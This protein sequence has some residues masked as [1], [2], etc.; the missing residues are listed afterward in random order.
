MCFIQLMYFIHT[1]YYIH[2]THCLIHAAH[3][4]KRKNFI[5]K[6]LP[7]QVINLICSGI[8]TKNGSSCSWLAAP[9]SVASNPTLSIAIT[10]NIQSQSCVV[11]K[12]YP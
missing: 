1:L 8:A 2:L 6:P 4:F 10:Q 5:K 3:N 9:N 11:K 12:R 7:L